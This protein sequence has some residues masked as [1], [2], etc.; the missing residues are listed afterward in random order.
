M[1]SGVLACCTVVAS[2]GIDA[3][4]VVIAGQKH[5]SHHLHL[6]FKHA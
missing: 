1:K 4:I 3:I 6:P 2:I 5:Y